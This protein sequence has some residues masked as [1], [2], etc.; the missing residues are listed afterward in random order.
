MLEHLPDPSTKGGGLRPPPFVEPFVDGSGRCSSIKLLGYGAMRLGVAHTIVFGSGAHDI[1]CWA[2]WGWISK[3]WISQNWISIDIHWWTS[4]NDYHWW[5]SIDDFRWWISINDIHWWYP[6]MNINGYPSMNI[7]PSLWAPSMNIINGYASNGVV[8]LLTR[9]AL[10]SKRLPSRPF[11]GFSLFFYGVLLFF[12]AF[13]LFFMV[14]HETGFQRTGYPLIFINGYPS[15]NIMMDIHQ[16]ISMDIQFFGSPPFG[17]L[18]LGPLPLGPLS[19]GPEALPLG[20]CHRI[21]LGLTIEARSIEYTTKAALL[22]GSKIR[23]TIRR[24]RHKSENI[25]VFGGNM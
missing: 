13:L 23:K 8:P 21:A 17:L 18:P 14:F 7:V 20:P 6:S 24:I 12:I 25:F 19:L 5:I 1:F 15:M 10:P 11:H 16:W 9:S 4:I 2:P 22:S 3:N